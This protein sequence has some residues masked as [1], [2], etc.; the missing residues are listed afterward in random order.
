MALPNL[1]IEKVG[2]RRNS[3]ATPSRLRRRGINRRPAR[4]TARSPPLANPWAPVEFEVPEEHL[5][6]MR[7]VEQDGR[8]FIDT[9]RFTPCGHRVYYEE[10]SVDFFVENDEGR[11]G[12][13]PYLFSY[14]F[15]SMDKNGKWL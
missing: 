2:E 14:L 5:G 7:I 13:P 9:D 10:E 11:I 6:P 12:R 1:E 4:K 8:Q 15:E 3:L